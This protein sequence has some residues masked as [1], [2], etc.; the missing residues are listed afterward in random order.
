MTLVLLT[1]TP[2]YDSFAEILFFFNLFLWNDKKQRRD[3]RLLL[4]DFFTADG[5][6]V[7]PDV[8]AQF[9]GLCHQ[10]V[11]VIRGETPFTFP[12][13]LPPP[14]IAPYDRKVS[15][16]GTNITTPLKYLPLVASYVESP[17]QERVQEVSGQMQEDMIHTV[18][19]SP[20]GR[21]IAQCFQ[22]ATNSA[23]FHYR[24]ANDVIPFLS[25]T[26]I[27]RH[28]AKYATVI[29]SIQES[30][31]IVFVYSNYLIGGVRQFAMALE[32]HGFEPAL[33]KRMLENPSS[34]FTDS[35][36]GKYALLS[37]DMSDRE[38]QRLLRDIRS[39]SNVNG[40]LV[41]VV[42]GSPL[43][44]EGLDFKNVR[45]VHILDPWYNMSRIE[46]I[47][48]RGLRTCSHSSLPFEDQNCTIY[49]HIL[50]YPD[51]NKET[52][53]EYVYRNFIEEKAIKIAQIKRVLTESSVD[54]TTQLSTNQLPQDWQNLI[55]SQKRAEDGK[56]VS[57]PLSSLSAPTFEDGRQA[58]VC[59][60]GTDAVTSEYTRPL[61]SY[62]DVRDEIYN[63]LI[64]LF[65]KKPVWK[66]GELLQQLK[67]APEVVTYI[68][69]GTI[70]EKR[71]LKSADGR[72][73]TL[74]N[75]GGM[76]AFL[77][78]GTQNA[79]MYERTVKSD[80]TPFIS[81]DIK[82]EE[83]EAEAGVEE[84][85]EEEKETTLPAFK[86]GFDTSKFSK[87]ALDSF[88]L[89]QVMKPEDKELLYLKRRMPAEL[90]IP[91]LNYMVLGDKKIFD[92]SNKLVVPIGTELDALKAWTLG[93]MERIAN[94]IKVNNRI[95]CTTVDQS[96]KIAA[97]ETGADGHIQ[98]IT[99]TKTIEPKTCSSFDIRDLVAFANEF[100]MSIDGM[101]NK[102]IRCVFLSLLGRTEN[103]KTLWVRPEIWS[104][105]SSEEN[106][107]LFR[108]MIK[109]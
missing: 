25:P 75:K 84:S 88:I 39:P 58:L 26:N 94:E 77:P 21:S 96:F 89:D 71:K 57:M 99:R 9:R 11:S 53:D 55:V 87:D 47:I 20:D 3:T 10:Y 38:I 92:E 12:F 67:Y 48:G 93:H 33:G 5:E 42:I 17:Q 108:A 72:V 52:Y 106:K 64:E 104:V 56:I 44:S 83:E 97:F 41:R 34:E 46:Q 107:K 29:K 68:V 35:S 23:K 102:D 85:K 43:V 86:F 40:Q 27:Q 2:M 109:D 105:L 6:F 28:A 101:K 66:E 45:Q 22:T 31:G 54:C 60:I 91:G 14:K 24:Y 51:S 73:G 81:L 13:R 80:T 95:I 18:V 59:S 30:K 74:E 90:V 63:K 15:F 8:E 103:P 49:L 70:H 61:S 76:Y 1:A 69:E 100:G 50:R 98:R 62:L 82:E 65:E 7:T 4:K 16:K 19:V 79:T 37:S 32:E 36:Q 78:E